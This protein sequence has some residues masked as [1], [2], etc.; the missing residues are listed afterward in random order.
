LPPDV[1]KIAIPIAENS[2]TESGFATTLTEAVRDRFEQFGV[3]NVVDTADQADATL[4]LRILKVSRDSQNVTA[5]TD[6]SL[7]ENAK[8]TMW[9]ELRRNNGA[10]L[11]RN[12]KLEVSK[13]FGTTAGSVVTSS[14]DFAAGAIGSTDLSGL[15]SREIQRGQE[16]E[17]LTALA[18]QTAQ[19]IYD[20]AVAPDF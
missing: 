4:H 19:I 11:W 10:L 2:S 18:E 3:V 16:Q 13:T 12:P 5:N 14:A 15:S 17:A 6:T 20:Q 1:S 9:G 7:Q 8:V